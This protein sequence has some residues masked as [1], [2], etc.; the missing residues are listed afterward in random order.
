MTIAMLIEVDW[1][2]HSAAA[3]IEVA[4]FAI[5]TAHGRSTRPA[6]RSIGTRYILPSGRLS[7][8]LNYVERLETTKICGRPSR[9]EVWAVIPI[10]G[11]FGRCP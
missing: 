1:V 11:Q 6:P 4:I 5:V 10:F 8:E 2:A 9:T 7:T 3:E